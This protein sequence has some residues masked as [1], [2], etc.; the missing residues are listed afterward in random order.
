M[1]PY[2]ASFQVLHPRPKS[3]KG[4]DIVRWAMDI[5]EDEGDEM[6]GSVAQAIEYLNKVGVAKFAKSGG[7]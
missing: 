1:E 5:A 3:M 4:L 7:Q 6:P 2:E